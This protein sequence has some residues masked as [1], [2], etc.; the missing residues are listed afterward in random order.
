M[1]TGSMKVI[2][3][4]WDDTLIPAGTKFVSS[5]HTIF[6]TV[7][8]TAVRRQSL[9]TRFMRRITFD[10]WP[11]GRHVYIPVYKEERQSHRVTQ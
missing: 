11:F 8:N 2:R 9:F 10:F 4:D 1:S 7:R 5:N 6:E 3:R